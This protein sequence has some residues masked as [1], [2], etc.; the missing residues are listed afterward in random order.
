[1]NEEFEYDF[2]RVDDE[3]DYDDRGYHCGI[4]CTKETVANRLVAERHAGL[5]PSCWRLWSALAPAKDH[6][7]LVFRR[8]AV[9]VQS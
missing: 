4:L 3:P 1:M 7:V 8:R 5:E 2:V 9:V 6:L